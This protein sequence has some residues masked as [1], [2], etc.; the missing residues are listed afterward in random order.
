M[1][2]KTTGIIE[3]GDFNEH[4]PVTY[5]VSYLCIFVNNYTAPVEIQICGDK[6]SLIQFGEIEMATI[7]TSPA[8]AEAMCQILRI[9]KNL[10][11]KSSPQK[12]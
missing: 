1:C 3:I 12:Q 5:I 2:F 7:I 10:R 11:N 8:I 6:T 9:I 4:P